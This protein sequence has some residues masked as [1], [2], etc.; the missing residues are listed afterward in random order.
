MVPVVALFPVLGCSFH[1]N[2]AGDLTFLKD[3]CLF[4]YLLDLE[5]DVSGFLDSDCVDVLR[6]VF[7][8]S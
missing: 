6:S 8:V 1:R 3:V 4:L 2:R 7:E 5:S